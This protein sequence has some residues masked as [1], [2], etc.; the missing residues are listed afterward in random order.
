M[1][2]YLVSRRDDWG[3]EITSLVPAQVAASGH[4]PTGGGRGA[5]ACLLN[6]KYVRPGWGLTLIIKIC[7][8]WLCHNLWRMKV[9]KVLCIL[10]R[11]YVHQTQPGNPDSTAR[12]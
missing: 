10:L 9:E 1:V 7:E 5:V 6:T 2:V 3:P 12:C 8:M 11:Y 4:L